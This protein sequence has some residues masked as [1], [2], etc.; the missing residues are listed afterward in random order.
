[1]DNRT[2]PSIADTFTIN[3]K[4]LIFF[5]MSTLS[6]EFNI[7]GAMRLIAITSASSGVLTSCSLMVHE[8][9]LRMSTCCLLTSRIPVGKSKDTDEDNEDDEEEEEDAFIATAPAEPA[10][11]AASPAVL[12]FLATK[13]DDDDDDGGNGGSR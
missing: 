5:S 11:P 1:M 13:D 9:S 6:L 2:A 7:V 8:F 12:L 4:S 10:A 3:F